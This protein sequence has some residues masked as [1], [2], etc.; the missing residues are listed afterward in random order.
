MYLSNLIALTWWRTSVPLPPSIP[1]IH[2][3]ASSAAAFETPSLF[4]YL[5]LFLR[6][7]ILLM[8]QLVFSPQSQPGSL[9]DNTFSV[10]HVM[11]SISAEG[12]RKIENKTKVKQKHDGN[13]GVI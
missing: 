1:P 7:G 4:P 8:R 5:F 2:T 3:A 12:K 13:L 9:L 6:S 11:Y 10:K